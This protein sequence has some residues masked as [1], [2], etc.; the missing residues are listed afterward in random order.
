MAGRCVTLGKESREKQR[1]SYVGERGW[2][3]CQYERKDA[4]R[5]SAMVASH[6]KFGEATSNSGFTAQFKKKGDGGSTDNTRPLCRAGVSPAAGQLHSIL[7]AIEPPTASA[8][9]CSFCLSLHHN[10]LF[11]P[12]TD[13][14]GT[15]HI[16]LHFTLLG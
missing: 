1:E 3:I 13:P 14:I 2:E 15:S 12:Q 10:L 11:W 5:I 4:F 8:F 16:G 6:L 9:V 7:S